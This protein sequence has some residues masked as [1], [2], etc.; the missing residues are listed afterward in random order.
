M[1]NVLAERM[2]CREDDEM[3]VGRAEGGRLESTAE[4]LIEEA[5][6]KRDSEGPPNSESENDPVVDDDA[7][8]EC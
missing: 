2:S 4:A 3:P 6:D 7:D 1:R 5:A 8:S